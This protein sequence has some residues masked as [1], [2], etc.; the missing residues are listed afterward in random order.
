MSIWKTLAKPWLSW[1]TSGCPALI[2]KALGV[3]EATS[4][5]SFQSAASCRFDWSSLVKSSTNCVNSIPPASV[6]RP[7]RPA[8]PDADRI[9]PLIADAL[10]ETMPDGLD[11]LLGDEATEQ[12]LEG[13]C[14]EGMRRLMGLAWSEPASL[15]DYLPDNTTVVVDER[16]HGM[17]HGQ[18]WLDHAEDHH[19]DMAAELGLSEAER[20][21]IWP[22]LLHREISSA[23]GLTERFPGFDL[24]ELLEEDNHPNS[25]DL[26]SRPVPAYPNQ[27]GKLAELI[28]RFQKD[29]TAV[30]LVSAQPSR[31]VA[32]LEEHDCVSRFIPNAADGPAID[33]LIE[34]NTPVGLKASRS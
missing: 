5:T 22:P 31:A 9:R 11:R 26:A 18:Q 15:L 16:R 30:W 13:G 7:C 29:R 34:Q 19:K 24:G 23:Y 1:A 4:S 12:L 28:K 32:L 17:A 25:F 8:S 6:R 33:R 10:R 14:P 2:R 3:V 27:F 21:V 20:D